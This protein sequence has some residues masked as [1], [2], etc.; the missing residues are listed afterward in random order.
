MTGEEAE[1]RAATAGAATG[2]KADT[3]VAR[4]HGGDEQARHFA[5]N[6]VQPRAS[7]PS[8]VW[9]G[10]GDVGERLNTHVVSLFSS[11]TSSFLDVA[12]QRR[13]MASLSHSPIPAPLMI[14][15]LPA[16][17]HEESLDGPYDEGN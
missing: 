15:S 6:F 3:E 7:G 4:G 13:A 5:V 14:G 12:T 10:A 1:R 17:M 9:L 2:E 16:S 11:S 8:E